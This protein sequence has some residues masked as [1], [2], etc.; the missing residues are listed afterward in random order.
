MRDTTARIAEDLSID[1]LIYR[2]DP[3]ETPVEHPRP[4]GAFEASF[5]PCTF[6]LA[7][8][9]AM[10]G[11]T[12]EAEQLLQRAESLAGEMGLFSEEA[13]PRSNELIGNHPLLFSQVEYVRAV[14]SLDQA[15]QGAS[16]DRGVGHPHSQNDTA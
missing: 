1:G 4:L 6:W 2:F 10:A 16:P 13:D 8:A 12:H 14:L 11:R 9:Y 15:R 5:L 3:Q 7:T